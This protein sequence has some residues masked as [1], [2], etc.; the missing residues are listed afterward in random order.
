[1]NVIDRLLF[2]K[3]HGWAFLANLKFGLCPLAANK[4]RIRRRPSE[5]FAK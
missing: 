2:K 1:L 4:C 3:F 5:K